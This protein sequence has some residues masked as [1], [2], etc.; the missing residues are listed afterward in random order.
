MSDV[1]CI[2]CGDAHPRSD[3]FERPD[4]AESSV[5][6]GCLA[7]LADWAAE[8]VAATRDHQHGEALELQSLSEARECGPTYAALVRLFAAPS[9][10]AC[11]PGEAA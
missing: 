3:H 11:D 9:N 8:T 1:I 5:C 7:M 2:L 6:G 10:G 4:Q